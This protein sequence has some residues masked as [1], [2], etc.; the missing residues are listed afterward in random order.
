MRKNAVILGLV[1]VGTAAAYV[2]AMD[3]AFVFDDAALLQNPLVTDP[4]A[5]PPSAWLASSRPAHGP[6]RPLAEL[7]FALNYL[8]S[9]TR[10][11]GWHLTNVAIH[12]GVI[13]LAWLFA[14][15]TFVRA[16][17]ARPD[18]ISLAAAGLFAL[19]PMQTESVAYIT[20]RAE[21]LASGFFLAALLLLLRRD[22][23]S[24]ARGRA[25][26]LMGSIAAS[27]AGL[28]V[29][30][31]VV[32]LPAAWLLHAAMIPTRAEAELSAWR[33][34]SRRLVAAL[35]FLGLGVAVV[36]W[37][38]GGVAGSVHAGFSV[39]G[40]SPGTYLATQL[41]VIPT[42][43]QLLGWPVG[44]CADRYFAA[45]RGFS[46]PQVLWGAALVLGI[47]LAALLLAARLRSAGGDD[48]GA[49][50]VACF[51]VAFFLL[52]LAPSSSFFPLLDP[53]AE[54][55]VY[56]PSLGLFLAALAWA[57]VVVRRLAQ[58]HAGTVS[59][60]LVALVLLAGVVATA[61][62]SAVW[63]TPSRFYGDTEAAFDPPKAR[64]SK[65]L[66]AALIN[67]HRPAEA[68]KHLCRALEHSADHS[69]SQ[70]EVDDLPLALFA[71]ARFDD[72][73]ID[74]D[75]LTSELVRAGHCA[76]AL[77]ILERLVVDRPDDPVVLN[78]LAACYVRMGR[79]ADAERADRK[80]LQLRR[81]GSGGAV[82]A[83]PG[84]GAALAGAHPVH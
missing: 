28:A 68:V 65:N 39:P 82:A 16:G 38:L 9:G 52:V 66:A 23:A 19:H 7:T 46:E 71:L 57:S 50:R 5:N 64:V 30:P 31:I 17:V 69:L 61:R 33:R 49:A 41:R 3:G 77:R 44:Q 2:P 34:V 59:G 79:L 43:L 78:K 53:Y 15:L 42:Y 13:V 58:T 36:A 60:V 51:G 27:A 67:A 75:L 63:A 56:L 55:R 4:F 10:P 25:G 18:G 29:K 14:R 11:W 24:T 72:R 22:E 48:P 84:P 74:Y 47:M 35:P 83:P 26:L 20:Q 21:S 54:H 76:Q 8:A 1:L 80:A 45:S 70:R 37:A 81:A 32:T 40:L 12:L 6:P 73:C 62:R